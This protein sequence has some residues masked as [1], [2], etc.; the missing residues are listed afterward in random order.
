MS[1]LL[2][3]FSLLGPLVAAT[4]HAQTAPPAGAGDRGARTEPGP[5]TTPTPGASIPVP[6]S[7]LP[8]SSVSTPSAAP[9]PGPPIDD[10]ALTPPA[11]P[12]KVVSG[13]REAMEAV[14][15]R[16]TDLEISLADVTRAEAQTRVA[17]AG[18]LPTL[19][20][21]A[22]VSDVLMRTTT[23]P[24][25]G[26]PRTKYF[27]DNSYTY[28]GSLNLSIPVFA[29]R[30]WYAMGTA[31][32]SLEAS[33]LSALDQR[34]I[35][36]ANVASTLV[37][38]VTAER[39]AELN[40]VGLR[41]ALERLALT[42]R[43]A[44]LGAATGLD[45]IRVE[46]DAASA[47]AQ[48]VSGDESLRQARE[49]LG[50]ALGFPDQIGVPPSLDLAAVLHDAEN[51]CPRR[52]KLADRPDIAALTQRVDIAR[53]GIRDVE[54][55]F[56]PT[57]SVDS[58]FSVFAQPFVNNLA[59]RTITSYSWSV[60]ASLRWNIFDGGVRYGNLRDASAVVRQAEARLEAARRSATIDVARATRGVGVA[61]DT[62][63]VSE[64]ARD[65]A[66]ETDRLARLSFELGKGTSLDLVDAARK[67]RE[68]EIQVALKDFDVV[69]SKVRAQ[70]IS[71]TCE[72]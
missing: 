72:L 71:S 43:R 27:P 48:I 58:T 57:A 28:G 14:R 44:E 24:L 19:S 11:K 52:E 29:P 67:L 4:A 56:M 62:R 63:K 26:Q 8:G 41:A 2:Y 10:P 32:R 9:P 1:K 3:F 5:A 50:L 18:A 23:N 15:T 59:D 66:K 38:V 7:V 40:R 35:L 46:Q 37:S 64:T 47:R 20:G 60:S 17:L 22:S 55:A 42:R 54:L 69:Q 33:R 70:L 13:W 21:S 49:N 6:A 12:T 53:R 36:A 45:V 68:S 16:S 65:L 39:I 31:D 51:A 30:A 61:D 34:R 25:T